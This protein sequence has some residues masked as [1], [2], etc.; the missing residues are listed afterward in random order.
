MKRAKVDCEVAN[1]QVAP[2]ATSAQNSVQPYWHLLESGNQ[3]SSDN[4][5]RGGHAVQQAPLADHLWSI[6]PE[7]L[8]FLLHQ[9]RTRGGAFGGNIKGACRTD[10]TLTNTNIHMANRIS[11]IL[12]GAG[13]FIHACLRLW[14]YQS[15]FK[16]EQ[17]TALRSSTFIS[18][19]S[20]QVSSAIN[21]I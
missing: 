13:T 19:S 3:S 9:T 17:A 10:L 20:S 6:R 7:S 1:I 14:Q 2:A 15:A 16:C 8:I 11:E 21:L 18:K 5:S 4:I 12:I